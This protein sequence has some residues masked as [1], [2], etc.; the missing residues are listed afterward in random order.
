MLTD[1]H[2]HLISAHFDGE[3]QDLLARARHAGVSRVIT[4][5]TDLETSR[6]GL[7]F[8]RSNASVCAT[9]GIHPT[10][11]TEVLEEDW[12]AKLRE[13]ASDPACAAIG[14]TGLDFYHPAPEGWS[15]EDYV[16][17]QELFFAAQLE[18]A[19]SLGKNIVVHQ[20]DRS[21]DACWQRILQMVR[22]WNGKLRAVFHC[23]LHPWESAREMVEQG[24]LISF[25]GIATYR[26]APVVA[27]CA[28]EAPS[29]SF[30][31]ET[32]SPYLAPVPHRGKRNEPAFLRDTA[33]WIAVRCGVTLEQLAMETNA[34]AEGF[35]AGLSAESPDLPLSVSHS[36]GNPAPP[37]D[38]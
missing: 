11:V 14:E 26:N 17:R 19:A 34:V 3:E 33:E 32:D 20:R 30:M 10:H 28:T 4:I 15:W 25:T 2:A 7:E 1:S 37:L 5:G 31:L 12:C 21:G 8:A 36:P 24:H 13:L 35:F 29:G 16:A 18:L 27:A 9:A 22:P 6:K 23:W 38:N